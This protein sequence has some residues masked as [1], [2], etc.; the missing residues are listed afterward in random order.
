M[1][2]HSLDLVLLK[3]S[4][5]E[6]HP[7][8]RHPRIHVQ[9]SPEVEPLVVSRI[10]G[11][12][13]ALVVHSDEGTFS[14]KL[15][16][17]DW[18]TGCKRLQHGVSENAYSGLTF[19]SPELLVVPNRVLSHFE[20]WHLPPSQLNPNPPVQ[21]LSLK[22]PGVSPEYSL[23]IFRCYGE[24]NPFLHSVPYLPPRPFFSSPENS[25]IMVA[26]RISSSSG[27]R[28]SYNLIMHRRA[29]L[30]TIQTWTSPS[31]LEQQEYLWLTNE[32]TVHQ[33]ADPEDG[34][35]QLD[36]QS[37]L[38][39]TTPHPRS[40][41][42]TGDSP[43]FSTSQT[44]RTFPTSHISADSVDSGSLSVSSGIS[45][46][47]STSRY[48]FLQVPW[49]KW[50]PPISRWFQVNETQVTRSHGQRYAFS[51]ANAPDGEKLMVSVVDFNPHKFRRNAEMMA[52]LGSGE[53]ENNS[54]N[55]EGQEEK[56]EGFEI[57]DHKG[58]F[59]EEVY[60]G[61]KCLVYR[62]PDEYDFDLVLMEEK[63]L[64]G[65]KLDRHGWEESIKVFYIG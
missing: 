7:L 22:I 59:S 24:P 53:G 64:F 41:P 45:T 47:S 33:I 31:L 56:A 18:K 5:G 43:T 38:V 48:T 37:K 11:D 27:R 21:I 28:A 29:L 14:D 32:V 60:M 61:L 23:R 35:V 25:I 1:Q 4:T 9:R 26:F 19:V 63:G 65:V 44:S 50:G 20:V 3:F 49:E 17:F 30:D 46:N 16:I 6:Y 15:F 2:R 12:N 42:R 10:V 40:S 36:A 62:T 8:A 51:D 55:E 57:L 52:R 58:V 13:L 54:N 34:S 39:S